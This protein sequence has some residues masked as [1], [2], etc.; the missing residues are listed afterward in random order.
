MQEARIRVLFLFLFSSV[1]K[2][3]VVRSIETS[4]NFYQA[5]QCNKPEDIFLHVYLREICNC[6]MVLNIAFHNRRADPSVT[7]QLVA[8]Q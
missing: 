3:E 2:M 6:L 1:L 7:E 8:S 4:S 5:T